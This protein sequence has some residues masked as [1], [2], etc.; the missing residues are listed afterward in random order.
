[1]NIKIRLV[2]EYPDLYPSLQGLWWQLE[3]QIWLVFQ[4]PPPQLQT[5]DCNQQT[6]CR[7]LTV[8]D[9]AG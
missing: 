9:K 6:D 1:V 4:I 7:L 2:Q 8:A 3:L 5:N